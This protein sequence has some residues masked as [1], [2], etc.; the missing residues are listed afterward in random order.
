RVSGTLAFQQRG[1]SAP[2][3]EARL[4]V[5]DFARSGLILSSKPLDLLVAGNLSADAARLAARLEDESSQLG[6]LDAR[7]TDLG[8]A[9]GDLAERLRRGRLDASLAYQGAAEALWRLLAIE[10]FDLTGP[11]NLAAKATGTLADPRITG[12][13]ASDDLRLQSAVSG[14]DITGVSAR[15]RFAGSRLELTRFAG[16]TSGG[17]T[18]S[19][20]GT[21]DLAPLSDGLGPRLD[22]RAAA[23]RARLLGAAGLDATL[24]GP[25][26]I[27]SSGRGGTIAGR[28][29]IER[30][31]WQLG[32]AAEDMSLP[33][34]ATRE[35]NLPASLDARSN[36]A[37]PSSWRYLVDAKA[38]NR[39]AVDG[40]GLDSEWGTD[41]QLR[42]TLDDPRIG[43]EAFLVRGSYTFAG[44]RFDLTR[45]RIR[46]D[47]D[48]PIDPR[49][50]IAA[51]TQT[52]NAGVTI[53]ITGNSEAPEI[54]FTS[55]PPLPEEEILA[56]L[57]F[58]G[59]VTSLSA[60]DAVQL[61]AALAALRGGESGLDPI[62]E[63]RR[64]IG[65]DQLRIVSADPAIGRSTGV[66]L[67]KNLGR[68][69][70]VELITDGRGYSA[71][72]LE[73]RVTRWLALL[74]TV[75]TIGRDNV[76]ARIS[77]DY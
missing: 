65:L 68:R 57:L 28:V 26:R 5:D 9:P 39:V 25:L 21:V 33:Q 64:S 37:S 58:G 59:S 47:A 16:E 24:T 6:R 1:E 71:T 43:G 73:Y 49:L 66:A 70:Y 7:I 35:V 36:G 46:F 14:T 72:Q 11:V 54:A 3:G 40:L 51:E 61:G 15:G 34:I 69:I 31:S 62:G 8:T 42:G 63:L 76:S 27:V 74:G 19:G 2:T 10:S 48:V 29:T 41:I 4:K 60:T 13:V 22:I 17:G 44:T 12:D 77:R 50:D 52:A 30:G 55:E 53:A 45:G 18:I 67:G 56:Q 32:Y 20:S 75:T 38:D 23:S